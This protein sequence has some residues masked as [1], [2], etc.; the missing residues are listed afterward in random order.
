[1]SYLK[2]QIDG[3]VEFSLQKIRYS[4]RLSESKQDLIAIL[5]ILQEYLYVSTL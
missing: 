1:M 2:K 5:C 4:K 3:A